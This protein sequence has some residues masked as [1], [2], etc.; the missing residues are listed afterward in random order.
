MVSKS[1]TTRNA[2]APLP[3]TQ[4]Y[5]ECSNT[6]DATTNAPTITLT[7]FLIFGLN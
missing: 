1:G 4:Y 2:I 3:S 5:V 7:N 6:W